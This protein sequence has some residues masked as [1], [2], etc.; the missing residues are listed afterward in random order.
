MY[1]CMYASFL[2]IYLFVYFM[3]LSDLSSCICTHQKI[4]LP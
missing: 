4:L 2:K 1:V 3:Y